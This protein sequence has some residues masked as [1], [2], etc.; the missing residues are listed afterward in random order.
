MAQ[1]TQQVNPGGP[2]PAS[3]LM[4]MLF[5][6]LTQQCICVAAKLRIADL[7]AQHPQTITELAAKT[8]SNEDALYRVLR[9]L[10]SVGIFMQEND[11]FGLTPMASL[12][13]SDVPDSI[14]HLALMMG[15]DWIWRNWGELMYSVQTGKTAHDKVHGMSTFEYFASN[16]KAG[17]V[18]NNAMTSLSK[19]VVTPI[20]EAYDFSRA[21]KVADIAGGHG[22]LLSGV[23]KA[24]PNLSGVLFDLPAVI[25]GAG[26]LLEKEGV[27]ERVEVESGN[28]FNS[29]PPRADVYLLKHVIH[30][31]DDARAIT[32]LKNIRSAI[33]DNSK[34]LIVEAI[35]P[36]NNEPSLAKMMDILMMVMEGGKERTG[37]EYKR[38]LEAA[39]LKLTRIIPTKSPFSLVEAE[40]L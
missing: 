31:C 35:V 38:L 10:S 2:P 5:G 8:S 30:A 9:M 11:K 12:L 20:V 23:L 28:F 27:S 40:P 3:I 17:S 33:K 19:G 39:D 22:M 26:S 34:V 36:E 7:V 4:Q 32:L 14:Y 6:G 37:K 1:G 21:S 16:P 25:Q 15:E 18:F 24:Y 29:V 13:R